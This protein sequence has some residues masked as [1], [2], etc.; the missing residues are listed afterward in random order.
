MLNIPKDAYYLLLGNGTLTEATSEGYAVSMLF[1]SCITL[2]FYTNYSINFLMYFASGRKFRT[3]AKD[4]IAC[5]W[6][7]RVQNLGG[8]QVAVG[9]LTVDRKAP[10]VVTRI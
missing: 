1:F 3:A 5:H 9:R 6:C 4:T 8:Q 10:Y 2:L 7:R